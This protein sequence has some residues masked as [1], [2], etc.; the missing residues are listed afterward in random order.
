MAF[1]VSGRELWL[2]PRCLVSALAS[3]TKPCEQ[4]SRDHVASLCE[5][6]A[7]TSRSPAPD[8]IHDL[9][10]CHLPLAQRGAQCLGSS[11]VTVPRVPGLYCLLE[12]GR[13]VWQLRHLE[14]ATT[15][16]LDVMCLT[17]RVHLGTQFIF[18]WLK[19]DPGRGFSCSSPSP[20][21]SSLVL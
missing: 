12:H 2:S 8:S 16:C 15:S 13:S 9:R 19:G 3:G 7:D 11:P 21:F 10:F 6:W 20:S 1:S 18:H 17:P 5:V 14:E 4:R